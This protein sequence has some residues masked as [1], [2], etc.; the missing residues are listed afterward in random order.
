MGKEQ[1]MEDRSF[2]R[3][4]ARIQ[5]ALNEAKKQELAQKYGAQFGTAGSHLPPEVES[6]W[7]NY[8][9]EFER[10]FENARRVTVREFV[11][12]PVFKPVSEVPS[13]HLSSEIESILEFLSLSSIVVDFLCDV[14]EAEAYRFLTIELMDTETDDVRIEGMNHHFTYEEFHPNDEY[15][16]KMF[17]EGFLLDLFHRDVDYALKSVAQSELYNANGTPTTVE[18]MKNEITSFLN[19]YAAFVSWNFEPVECVVEGDYATVKMQTAWNGL[20]A[21][22]ME[23]ISISGT[24]TL[25]MKRNPYGGFDVIQANIAGWNRTEEGIP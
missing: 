13:E 15:D 12:N 24:S 21:G 11:G 17:A 5:W 22:T 16:A 7:L 2:D 19:H 9:E 3:E 10:Q 8:V 23:S 25:R 18:Q 6:R 4:Q 1:N 20:R 14:A